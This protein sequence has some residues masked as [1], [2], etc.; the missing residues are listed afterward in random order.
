MDKRKPGMTRYNEESGEHQG[1]YVPSRWLKFWGVAGPA[2]V[3]LV[4]SVMWFAARPDRTE[5]DQ[6]IQAVRSE[7]RSEIV[8]SRNE[9]RQDIQDLRI[10]LRK[11]LRKEK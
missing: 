4:G 11:L 8:Q 6:K 10:E 2:G 7:M 3:V 9:I 1:L 5:M